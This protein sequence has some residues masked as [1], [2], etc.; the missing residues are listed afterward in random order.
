MKQELIDIIN[1]FKSSPSV[2]LTVINQETGQPLVRSISA[3]RMADQ[4]GLSFEIFASD[5][6]ICDNL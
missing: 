6:L 2:L 3:A 4:Y 1:R 5:R